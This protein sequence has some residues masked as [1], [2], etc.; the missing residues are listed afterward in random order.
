M[1]AFNSIITI[2]PHGLPKEEVVF[3]VEVGG[4]RLCHLQFSS[5]WST[6]MMLLLINKRISMKHMK[7]MKHMGVEHVDRP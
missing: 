4:A 5:C 1:I 7:H 2:V 3:E 6:P